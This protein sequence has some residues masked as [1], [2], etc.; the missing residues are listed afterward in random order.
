[1]YAHKASDYDR[2]DSVHNRRCNAYHDPDNA[3]DV[4]FMARS[5]SAYIICP[6]THSACYIFMRV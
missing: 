1:M 4:A 3:D 5:G 2:V 6:H